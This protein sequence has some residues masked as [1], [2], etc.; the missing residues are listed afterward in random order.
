MIEIKEGNT[1]YGMWF[2]EP[3]TA[4]DFP[5][6]DFMG[7]MYK[8]NEDPIIF[9]YRFRYYNSNDPF[10]KED[11]KNW[12]VVHISDMSIER[13]MSVI[14]ELTAD[15]AKFF[16]HGKVNFLDLRGNSIDQIIEKMQNVPFTH[17]KK[18]NINDPQ[19]SSFPIPE[20]KI[21]SN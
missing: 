8:Q 15:L 11:V 13:F 17:M 5:E 1:F 10:D 19:F 20:E 3:P 6:Q 14:D 18:V 21:M 9:K 4:K 2:I 16:G 7:A 12:Y